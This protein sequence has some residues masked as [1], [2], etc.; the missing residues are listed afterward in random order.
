MEKSN[1][2]ITISNG[3]PHTNGLGRVPRPSRELQPPTHSLLTG[4]K[5]GDYARLALCTGCGFVFGL[6]AEKARG[7]TV[8]IAL[9]VAIHVYISLSSCSRVIP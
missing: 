2:N 1:K 5:G 8:H 9:D 6:A 4:L 7:M 3:V